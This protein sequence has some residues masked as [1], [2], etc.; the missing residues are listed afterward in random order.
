MPDYKI[1]QGIVD[2][3]K[4]MGI[5]GRDIMRLCDPTCRNTTAN[6]Y[7]KGR[8]ES[9]VDIFSQYGVNMFPG[10]A[11]RHLKIRSFKNRLAVPESGDT[12]ML[13]VYRTCKDFIRTIPQLC[14]AENMAEDIDTNGEDHA[15]DE[16]CHICMDRPIGLSEEEIREMK[17]I[18]EHETRRKQLDPLSMYVWDK[19]DEFM[20]EL[21]EDDDYEFDSYEA[22]I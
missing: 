9:T 16:A 19:H 21:I 8:G 1:A 3:E 14:Y 7:G 5:W 6:K 15:Y 2:R 11:K 12:P 20:E 18:E 4:K 10:D 22:F 17:D 13:V